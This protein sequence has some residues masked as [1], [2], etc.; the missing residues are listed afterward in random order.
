MTQEVL[1]IHI[2]SFRVLFPSLSSVAIATRPQ[3]ALLVGTFFMFGVWYFIVGFMGCLK[4][5][6]GFSGDARLFNEV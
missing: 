3:L 2:V 6:S 4:F 1:R 5:D